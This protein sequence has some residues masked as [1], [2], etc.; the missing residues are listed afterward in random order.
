MK[1]LYITP[2]IN[3][4]GGVARVLSLK[5]NFF[6]EK[7]NYSVG[8]ITQNKG[9]SPFFFDFN[10]ELNLFDIKLSSNFLF[11]FFQY[12]KQVQAILKSL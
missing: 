12:K 11:S 8:I 6:I 7:Y 4:S 5:T 10:S 2:K 3:T 9:N 1:I